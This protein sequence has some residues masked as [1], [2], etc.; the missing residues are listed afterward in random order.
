[1]LNMYSLEICAAESPPTK[2]PQQLPPPWKGVTSFAVQRGSFEFRLC[3]QTKKKLCLYE[4][5]SQNSV[6]FCKA[7]TL[8]CCA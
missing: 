1:M 2:T 3:V 5:A 4:F 7:C 8:E 6:E